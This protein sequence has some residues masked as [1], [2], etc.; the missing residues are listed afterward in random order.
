MDTGSG[1]SVGIGLSVLW[2]KVIVQRRNIQR[3]FR[4]VARVLV[5][6]LA[7]V[8]T[9]PVGTNG[10]VTSV[11]ASFIKASG[12]FQTRL[13]AMTSVRRLVLKALTRHM[14]KPVSMATPSPPCAAAVKSD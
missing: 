12:S 14:L 11:L 8:L 10:D 2:V 9:P 1:R 3:P 7:R 4:G 13:R 6:P 5:A